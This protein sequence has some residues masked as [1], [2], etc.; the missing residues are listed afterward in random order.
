MNQFRVIMHVYKKM[1]QGKSLCSYLKQ[2]K[3]SFFF[4]YKNREQEGI[5][6]SVWEYRY[7]WEGG[8]YEER[9]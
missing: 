2:I 1:S 3:M 9:V 8:E 5:T 4:F 7:Q 6:V